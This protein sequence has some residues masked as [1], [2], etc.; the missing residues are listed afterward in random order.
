MDMD[1][2]QQNFMFLEG[3]MECLILIL[4]II[5]QEVRM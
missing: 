1:S 2:D 5:Y 3:K 4:F